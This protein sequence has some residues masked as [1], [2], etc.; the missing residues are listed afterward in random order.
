[1][2][3][4]HARVVKGHL[5]LDEPTDLPEGTVVQLVPAIDDSEELSDAE[6]AALRPLLETSWKNALER[7][8]QP[9]EQTLRKLSARR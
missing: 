3:T 5:V 7:R 2:K 9:L 4:L 1:M 8:G 6:W